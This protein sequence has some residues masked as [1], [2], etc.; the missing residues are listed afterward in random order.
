[1]LAIP[2]HLTIMACLCWLAMPGW[3]A[4][5]DREVDLGKNSA[6]P[7]KLKSAFLPSAGAGTQLA[8]PSP[9]LCPIPMLK[10]IASDQKEVWLSPLRLRKQDADWLL[11]FGAF[12]AGLIASDDHIMQH[13]SHSPQQLKYSRDF[14]N[15]GSV[16]LWGAA[17]SF[18]LWGGISQS[19]HSR[20]TGLLA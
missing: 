16:A 4:A 3:C 20:E 9:C 1:M 12:S 17:G 5:Q 18:S 6:R 8:K 19:D 11:P 13:V 15:A 2:R 14:G 7:T 10:N